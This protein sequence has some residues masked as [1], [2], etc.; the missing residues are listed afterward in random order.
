MS[1]EGRL[2]AAV[3][4]LLFVKGTATSNGSLLTKRRVLKQKGETGKWGGG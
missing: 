1:S 2:S 4:I 3:E